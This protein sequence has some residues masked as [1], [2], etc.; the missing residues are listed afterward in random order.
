MFHSDLVILCRLFYMLSYIAVGKNSQ[1]LLTGESYMDF[2]LANIEM[3]RYWIVTMIT[4][5]G[6]VYVG[7]ILWIRV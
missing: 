6:G 2:F 3:V 4:E 1:G 7:N 5:K